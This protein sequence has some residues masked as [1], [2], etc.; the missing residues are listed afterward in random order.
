MKVYVL[1][2]FWGDNWEAVAVYSNREAAEKEGQLTC[3]KSARY[4]EYE[5]KEFEVRD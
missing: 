5:V 3:S 1:E 2:V 4:V